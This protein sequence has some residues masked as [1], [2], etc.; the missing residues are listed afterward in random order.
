LAFLSI[1]PSTILGKRA[2]SAEKSMEAAEERRK[3]SIMRTH[4]YSNELIKI[5]PSVI[6]ISISRSIS[7]SFLN[8]IRSMI[9]PIKGARITAGSIAMAAVKAIVISSAP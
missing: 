7:I 1:L 9:I 5:N 4:I 2:I 3:I 8:S 6:V